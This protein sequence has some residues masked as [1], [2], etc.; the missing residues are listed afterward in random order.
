MKKIIKWMMVAG[1]VVAST[2]CSYLDVVPDNVTNLDHA[3][4]NRYTAEQYLGTCYWHLPFGD[5]SQN[6]A[7]MGSAETV[8]NKENISYGMEVAR[9]YQNTGNPYI[10]HWSGGM[11]GR[12]MYNG[13]R[14][15][16]TFLENI[17][18]VRDLEETER[19]RWIAEVKFIKAYLHFWLLRYYGPIHIIDENLP[20]YE[21]TSNV[22][23]YRKPIDECFE[24]VLNLLDEVINSKDLPN[25]IQNTQ[26]E[27][28]RIT[29]PIALAF[30][31]RVAMF[32]ASPLFNGNTEMESFISKET[33][34]PF[35]NQVYDPSRWELA[36]AACDTAIKVCLDNNIRL[37][38]ESDYI[39]QYNIS[40][41]T[42]INCVL[43]NA[44]SERWNPELIW[45]NINAVVSDFFQRCSQPPLGTSSILVMQAFLGVS[46]NTAETFYSKNGVPIEEDV[47]YDYAN[48]YTLRT[49]ED[50]HKYYIQKGH[51]TAAL[52]FDREHR[53]YATLAFDR[54]KWYG[55]G[56]LD[57]DLE[58]WHIEGKLKEYSSAYEPGKYSASGYWPKKYVSLKSG[59]NNPD[60]WSATTYPWPEIRFA[61]LL[62]YYAEAL[63]EVK[64][65]P[66]AEV[67]KWIDMVR[68]RAGL[69]GV[70]ESWKKYSNQ[71][72]KP[73]TKTGMRE[74][75]HRE[76]MIELAC[77]GAQY[78][79][80][81]RWKTAPAE[82][83]RAVTGWNVLSDNNTD[84][85]TVQ[86]LFNQKFS[87]KDYFA[88]IP[89]NEIS[90]NPLLEQNPG[91]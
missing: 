89:E 79:D 17:G 34:K 6:P 37:Y 55:I 58:T 56:K 4:S 45:G 61:D 57:N 53:Y 78:W 38:Q 54:S 77:E 21:E 39:T 40:D 66:D 67:Y 15:C 74:I 81:R 26:Q 11:G 86:V 22:R 25:S 51:Q 90:V 41:S 3:F 20:V 33:G 64:D 23:H 75:I 44:F 73:L 1:V 5:W 19:R 82:L 24:Y 63:N 7:I 87:L 8:F 35:F 50:D 84:Y 18:K 29:Q 10:N 43:R 13:I 47:E 48:R 65:A 88:P 69:K 80:V 70:V 62:L 42:R 68:E 16:N 14:D 71:P 30:K 72:D 91:W 36:A 2:S 49:S 46:M 59:Y 31:A 12:N 27:L 28:G 9:G 83:N 32:Y 60:S 52:N 85:Y 76:R